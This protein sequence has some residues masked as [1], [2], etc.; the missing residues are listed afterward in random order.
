M[1][2]ELPLRSELAAGRAGGQTTVSDA[3]QRPVQSLRVSRPRR[4]AKKLREKYVDVFRA[5]AAFLY[6][7]N[8]NIKIMYMHQLYA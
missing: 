6:Q 4:T 8:N 2:G 1:E 7:F 3:R 5:R